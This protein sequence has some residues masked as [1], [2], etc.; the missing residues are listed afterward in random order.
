MI[1]RLI[2]ENFMTHKHT[3]LELHPNVTVLTGPNNTGKSAI[4]EALRCVAENPPSAQLIRH[5]ASKAVVRVEMNDGSWVQWERTAGS[6]VY[7]VRFANG[8]EDFYA[9]VG[10][11][12]VPEDIRALLRLHS[13]PTETG[14]VD[15]H[16]GHQKTPIF[17]L[18]QSGSQAA[19]F[20]AASTE[21]DYLLA[22]QQALKERT[23]EAQRERKRLLE[24][25]QQ[26]EKDL[27]AFAP[28]PALAQQ[29]AQAEKLYAH[30]EVTRRTVPVLEAQIHKADDLTQRLDLW[31]QKAQ[32]LQQ[33]ETP[34]D[35]HDTLSLQGFVN[36]LEKAQQSLQEINTIL[37]CLAPLGIPPQIKNTAALH[38][39][40]GAMVRTRRS[41]ERRWQ[42]S[43]VLGRTEKP[44]SLSNTE[45]LA[46]LVA[47]LDKTVQRLQVENRRKEV[48][49][50][51]QPPPA[52][53]PVHGMV[54]TLEALTERLQSLHN[55]SVRH[56]ALAPLKAPP[57]TRSL[58]D[59]HQTLKAL[60][61][62]HEAVFTLKACGKSL[63]ALASPPSLRDPKPVQRLVEA[64]E[65]L[66][67]Q[68]QRTRQLQQNVQRQ[69]E[70]KRQAVEKLLQNMPVCPFCRQPIDPHHF[71]ERAHGE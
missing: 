17:L 65:R 26:L 57:E 2:I 12:A 53:R 48:A 59:L 6:V 39:L 32:H 3:V 38:E 31:T 29:M 25:V 71:L 30:I 54:Q 35:V 27:L 21:A 47:R 7:R 23:A 22:V 67:E 61:T 18:D 44:P 16:I 58:Q 52:L 42:A 20:F 24:E 41:L 49:S 14:P 68:W 51:L 28:L 1:H 4:V 19:A 69:M 33:L 66:Q 43:S 40:V 45:A 10:R 55:T 63:K 60:E 64:M 56:D 5:G 37:G 62:M 8:T 36:R 34:P 11:G 13:L 46:R 15:V 9:K 70:E 50:T